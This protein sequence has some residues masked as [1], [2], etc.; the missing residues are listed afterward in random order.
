MLPPMPAEYQHILHDPR[1]SG[2]SRKL[3]LLFSF[4]A[5]ETDAALPHTREG[6]VAVQ[7]KL[8]TAHSFAIH[9]QSVLSTYAFRFSVH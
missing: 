3:N 4:A 9:M 1:I 5:L 7:G 8:I 6:F 2:L